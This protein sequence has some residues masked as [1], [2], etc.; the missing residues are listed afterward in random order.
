MREEGIAFLLLPCYLFPSVRKSSLLA[1][2]PTTQNHTLLPLTSLSLSLFPI[3]SPTT[4]SL[5]S[6]TFA[7]LVCT[8]HSPLCNLF[9]FLSIQNDVVSS[10]TPCSSSPSPSSSSSSFSILLPLS[11]F[12]L[13]ASPYSPSSPPL[14]TPPPPSPT[15]TRTTPTPAAG[16][17]FPA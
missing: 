4:Q 1:G 12:L 7:P 14:T 5:F 9:F 13:M 3:K 17:A 6:S 16:P 8:L 11:H 2:G 15:G 10:S